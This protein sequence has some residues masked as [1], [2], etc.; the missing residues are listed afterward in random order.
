[1]SSFY[2]TVIHSLVIGPEQERRD[3]IAAKALNNIRKSE[4]LRKKSVTNNNSKLYINENY[5]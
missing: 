3:F 1:M 2:P 4:L 5:Y